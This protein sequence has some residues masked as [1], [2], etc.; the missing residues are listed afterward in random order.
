MRRDEQ[1]EPMAERVN[2]GALSSSRSAFAAI[3]A[4]LCALATAVVAAPQPQ[5]ASER[6]PHAAARRAT[7]APAP[8][9]RPPEQRAPQPPAVETPPAP[10]QELPPL[11]TST[12]PPSLPRASR[13][14]MRQ[15]A[16]QWMK[17][18]QEG[19]TAGTSWREFATRCLTR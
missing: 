18:R 6:P 19:R 3:V 8:P 9:R 2:S 1:W 7:R 14:R 10:P 5:P 17:I 4:S 12:P 13:E 15:C 11:D 16:T